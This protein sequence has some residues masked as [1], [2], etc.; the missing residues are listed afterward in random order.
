MPLIRHHNPL[1]RAVDVTWRLPLKTLHLPSESS[2]FFPALHQT[3]SDKMPYPPNSESI[4]DEVPVTSS[5][6]GPIPT[7]TYGTFGSF[8]V[9][10]RTH[11]AATPSAVFT[12]IRDTKNW[13]K[14]NTF[15]PSVTL[16]PKSPPPQPSSDPNIPTGNPGYLE[17]GTIGTIDVFMNGDGLVPGRKRSRTQG[18][19]VTSLSAIV[20]TSESPKEGYRLSWKSTGFSH[21]QLHSERVMEFL[22]ITLENGEPGTEFS[23]WETFGGVLSS[24]VKATYGHTLV[25]RFGDYQRDVKAFLSPAP[26]SSKEEAPLSTNSAPA[27]EEIEVRT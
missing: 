24:L 20:P 27:Q 19:I 3:T 10:A 16:S 14:W 25:E 5:V 15:C 13:N 1:Y 11:V 6:A 18:I 2:N 23:C 8:S 17:L 7:P 4:T 26:T 21:W 22:A 12:L 9:L